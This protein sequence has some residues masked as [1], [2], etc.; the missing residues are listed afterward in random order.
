MAKKKSTNN[1]I[2]NIVVG[3][4]TLAIGAAVVCC[5]GYV[6][7]NDEGKWFSNP[8]LASW[9]WADKDKTNDDNGGNDN[10]NGGDDVNDKTGS[11]VIF[12][13]KFLTVA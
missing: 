11:N 8:D 5:V 13:K 3:L 2:A 7:R 9:H 1:A 6:S 10:N 4:L 12:R